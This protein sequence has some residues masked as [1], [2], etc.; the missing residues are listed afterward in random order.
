MEDKSFILTSPQTLS[1]NLSSEASNVF[2]SSRNRELCVLV[3]LA[4]MADWSSLPSYLVNRIDEGILVRTPAR[5][6]TH[7]KD[8]EDTMSLVMYA[9][10][11]SIAI[12]L[13][14]KKIHAVVYG[15]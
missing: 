8:T 14:I 2:N 3:H 1:P 7:L 4:T 5:G 12:Y 13:H 10:A 15:K 9:T 11:F 6:I